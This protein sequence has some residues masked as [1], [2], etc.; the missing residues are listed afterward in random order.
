MHFI[1]LTYKVETSTWITLILLTL[2]NILIS[3]QSYLLLTHFNPM[4]YFYIPLE[5]SENLGFIYRKRW[6]FQG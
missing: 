6:R 1:F 3:A 4:F 5:T 2:N